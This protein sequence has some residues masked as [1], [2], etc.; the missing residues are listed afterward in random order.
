MNFTYALIVGIEKYEYPGWDVSG[1]CTNA[2]AITNWLLS[3]GTPPANLTLFLNPVQDLAQQIGDLKDRGVQVYCS[4]NSDVI[5]T[6]C[7]SNLGRECPANSRLL[8]YWSGHGCTSKERDRIFFCGDYTSKQTSHVFY[9]SNFLRRLRASDYQCFSDQIVLADVCGVYS[10]LPFADVRED[11]GRLHPTRQLAFFATPEGKYAYGSKG[12][13]VFTDT[14]LTVLGQVGEW[15][16]DH[17]SVLRVLVSALEKV[18]QIPFRIYYDSE[19]EMREFMVGSVPKDVGN[20]FFISVNALL[21]G[22]SLSDS[23]FRPHYLRTVNELGMPELAKAQGLTG[24]IQELSLLR[25]TA[26]TSQMPYGLLQ[27]LAR[28]AQE[29]SLNQPIND[30]LDKNAPAQKNA[31]ATIREK[32]QLEAQ[33]KILVVT[34]EN[35]RNNE[36]KNEVTKY[37]AVLRNNDFSPVKGVNFPSRTVKDWDEFKRAL[38]EELLA[39][40]RTNH[41]LDSFEIQEINFAVDPPLF[42][43]PFHQIPVM[44]GGDP[45]LGHEFIVLVRHR[46][47]NLSKNPN[48]RK[49]WKEYADAVRPQRPNSVTLLGIDSGKVALPSD[50]GLCFAGF[51]LPPAYETDLA[52]KN[53]KSRLGA[54][55]QLGAPYLYWLHRLPDGADWK[56]IK[57]KL[58]DMLARVSTLDGFPLQFLKE[59]IGGN[60]FATE[61][62]LLWDDPEFNPF[63]STHGVQVE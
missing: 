42:D 63:T 59:R 37:E 10:D 45:T 61:A 52:C 13:G 40:L 22:I 46:E 43:R 5:D 28:L 15:P 54:L 55:L 23:I 16:P 57:P 18:G 62:S 36:G 53:E 38:Q 1:P 12:R 58:T 17:D 39:K 60:E 48:F 49:F 8:V 26:I 50:K 51:L 41:S 3:I 31:L 27:F 35:D 20:D 34:V 21:S 4:A 33:L 29:K 24:M 30:W 56:A 32:L 19:K 44:P 25:D 7:R 9:A 11:P 2:L 14:A 47:R 6:Y